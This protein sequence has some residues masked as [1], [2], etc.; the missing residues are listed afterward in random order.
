MIKENLRRDG[1]AHYRPA[2]EFVN[3]EADE[4]RAEF[5]QLEI[6]RYAPDGVRRFR[7]YGNGI[8]IPWEKDVELFWIPPVVK[9]D[10]QYLAGYDQGGNN[11]EHRSIRYFN[12]LS[13][14]IKRNE[15]LNKLIRDDFSNTFWERNGQDFPI[16]FGVHF[17]KI[18]SHAMDDIGLSSPNCFHQDGEPFTFAHLVHR[19][20]TTKGG[21]NYIG[22]PS[23]RNRTLEEIE[24][25]DI[26][27]EFTLHQFLE[28]FAVFD[29]A[30]SHYVEPIRMSP[31]GEQVAERC[32]ILID[33][34]Q[35]RQDI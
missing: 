11:P 12:S 20:P 24:T 27:T 30:V 34:S 33:F 26:V 9:D 32:M 4:L 23:A 29:P 10:G 28:S 18:E 22:K 25:D 5:G 19:S 13:D 7:R 31:D 16:Y 14:R 3:V 15:L 6:D 17:V 2:V 8:I 35:T 1:Y 21:I